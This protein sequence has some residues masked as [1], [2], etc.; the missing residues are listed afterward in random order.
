[1]YELIDIGLIHT[2]G[3]CVCLAIILFL[4]QTNVS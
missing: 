2:S 4:R 1:M 3:F